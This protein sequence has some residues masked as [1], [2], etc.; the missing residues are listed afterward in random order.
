MVDGKLRKRAMRMRKEGC[1]YGMIHEKLRVPKG[2]LSYWLSDTAYKPN[3]Q[4]LQRIKE[5]RAKTSASRHKFKEESIKRAQAIAAKDISFLN[6]R[7]I[8]MLGLGLYIGEGAKSVN[9]AVVNSD[10]RVIRLAM[11]WL[12]TCFDLSIDNL[13]LSVHLYPDTNVRECLNYWAKMTG[14]PREQFGKT[15][16]DRRE[17]K[18]M[19]KRGKL[20]YGTAH[21]TVVSG[22]QKKFGSMVLLL[23]RINAQMD[24]VLDKAGLV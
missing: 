18:K 17:N 13:R 4:A 16:I 15:Q 8:F 10:A 22:G 19:A 2:T 12:I 7:D 24:I 3:L 5:G 14:I 9:V 23:R 21:L 6:R 20:R 11:Q 1:S